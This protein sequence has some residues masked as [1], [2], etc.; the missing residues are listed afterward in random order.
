MK[1]VKDFYILTRLLIILILFISNNS[2]CE[3]PI[4]GA[5]GVK[6]GDI[7]Q[8]NIRPKCFN[9]FCNITPPVNSFA[10]S[11]YSVYLTQ[12]KKI[13][14]ICASSAQQSFD[15]CL[16]NAKFYVDTVENMYDIKFVAAEN[17][18]VDIHSKQWT[19][20]ASSP[21]IDIQVNCID[22]TISPDFKKVRAQEFILNV[23]Y[24]DYSESPY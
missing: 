8:E 3:I 18:L 19:Y 12:N 15:E 6:F 21:S 11:D 5:F 22:N 20:I 1:T 13:Y 9:R 23:T 10:F 4:T 2:T 7:L 16:T 14:K 17:K 24:K